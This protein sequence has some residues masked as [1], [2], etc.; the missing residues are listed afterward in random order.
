LT[1]LLVAVLNIWG[2]SLSAPG[3]RFGTASSAEASST[4]LFNPSRLAP[5]G[6]Q[7]VD[8]GHPSLHLFQGVWPHSGWEKHPSHNTWLRVTGGLGAWLFEK[9]TIG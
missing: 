4:I 7:L 5:F 2:A 8:Q 9:L 1:V 6:N 3:S